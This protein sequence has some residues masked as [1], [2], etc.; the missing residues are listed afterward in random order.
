MRLCAIGISSAALLSALA[1][2]P[3]AAAPWTLLRVCLLSSSTSSPPLRHSCA[4]SFNVAA[5]VIVEHDS[6]LPD[7]KVPKQDPVNQPRHLVLRPDRLVA[8]ED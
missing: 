2:Q 5:I 4:P 7:K 8:L 6:Q 3:A 1:A